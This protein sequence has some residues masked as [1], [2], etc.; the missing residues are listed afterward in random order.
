MPDR[1]GKPEVGDRLVLNLE[2]EG[3]KR[4]TV[5]ATPR[6]PIGTKLK[7][8]IDLSDDKVEISNWINHLNEGGI[9]FEDE[10]ERPEYVK[11]LQELPK[12]S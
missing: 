1:Y 5:T 3:E 6:S 10:S 4:G 8:K 2:G 12:A 7:V 9:R 11:E